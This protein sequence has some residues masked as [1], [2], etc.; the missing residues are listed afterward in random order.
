[1]EGAELPLPFGAA[2][3]AG[4]AAATEAQE[5]ATEGHVDGD[6]LDPLLQGFSDDWTDIF[7]HRPQG[8]FSPSLLL[9]DISNVL[10]TRTLHFDASELQ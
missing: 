5:D 9:K 1:M 3:S 4:A 10:V 8:V 2:E 7:L 6:D